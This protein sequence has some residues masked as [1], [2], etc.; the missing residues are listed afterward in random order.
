MRGPR[1]PR[2]L[3]PEI[4][5]GPYPLEL[6]PARFE[7]MVE[8]VTQRLVRHLA[9]LEAAPMHRNRG[10]RKA[11]RALREPL[12]EAG[13]R[14]DAL[15]EHLFSRVLPLGLNTASA[16]YL[17]YIPGGGLLHGAVADLVTSAVNRYVGVWIAAPGLVEIEASVVRWLATI[18]GLP[19]GAGGVLT[20]G[21]SMANLIA[22]VAARCDRL[23]EAF[24]RGTLYVSS[25][26]HHSVTKAASIAGLPRA[27]VRAIPT[28]ARQR[29][30]VDALEHAIATDRA[31]GLVPFLVVGSA[32]TT[33]TGAVDPLHAL[34]DIAERE[35]LWFHVDAAYGGFFALTERGRA[36]LAGIERA[37][38]VTLD[39]HKGLFLPYGTGCVVVRDPNTLRR[40]FA[41]HASYLPEMQRDADLLDF[42]D[43]SPELSREPRG[44]RVWLP[45]KMH[46]ARAFREALDEKLDLARYAAAALEAW[47][48]IEI[49]TPP[50][51]SLFAFRVRAPG[52][53]LTPAA[54]DQLQRRVLR[55]VNARQRALLTGTTIDGRFVLRVCILS[56]RTHRARVDAALED[57]RASVDDALRSAPGHAP[58]G[59]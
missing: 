44:L 47:P 21:G 14:F 57:L 20:T 39:P 11:V 31:A 1:V 30:R 43:L 46:G 3:A 26:V 9:G 10:A 24:A 45:M 55:G 6:A 2:A 51:L 7:A 13:A 56:F 52:G 17:A 8:A 16:G 41:S 18:V 38:S 25:E 49:V 5:P 34:A 40:A 4:E 54:D 35:S 27:N 23:G 29:L 32:G 59:P 48:E 53:P 15:L 36:A 12:P 19:E 33:N 58:D 50:T 42:C 22:I 37:S 28:C